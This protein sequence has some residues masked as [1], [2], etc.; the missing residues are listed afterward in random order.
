MIP[1]T[2]SVSVS[3]PAM[4]PTPTRRSH[5]ESKA[6]LGNEFLGP[7]CTF[8]HGVTTRS[9]ISE[10]G[11]VGGPWG[12]PPGIYG[13]L[14][15]TESEGGQCPPLTISGCSPLFTLTRTGGS[16]LHILIAR[17]VIGTW[18]IS[19]NPEG[20]PQE[21]PPTSS[22]NTVSPPSVNKWYDRQPGG[23]L[24]PPFKPSSCSGY[25]SS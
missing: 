14:L 9:R 16:S 2:P 7:F 5:P 18:C 23:F 12:R 13:A 3:V 24:L 17:P 10:D 21:G 22:I 4:L 15:R 1:S 8:A 11:A 19:A 25:I 6:P 20:V